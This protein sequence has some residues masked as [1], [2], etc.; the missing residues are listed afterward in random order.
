M[1][2]IKLDSMIDVKTFLYEIENLVTEKKLEYID[3][4]VY[5]CDNNNMEVETAAS[6]IKQNQMMKAKVRVEAEDLHY[7]PKKSRLPI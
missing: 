3:A 7:L 4:I 1:N 5:Y 2:D 6:L